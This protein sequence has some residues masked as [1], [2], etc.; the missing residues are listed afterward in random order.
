M[1]SRSHDVSRIISDYHSTIASLKTTDHDVPITKFPRL[2]TFNRVSAK[3]RAA[4][5]DDFECS[6]VMYSSALRDRV[7]GSFQAFTDIVSCLERYGRFI[8][9]FTGEEN[10]SFLCAINDA[11]LGSSPWSTI[12][13]AIWPSDKPRSA[14]LYPELRVSAGMVEG[15][16]YLTLSNKLEFAVVFR[17]GHLDTAYNSLESLGT[18]VRF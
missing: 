18:G 5:E 12:I 2:D 11:P 4:V 7:K 10:V 1:A 17:F 14:C 13:N 8:I 9:D 16:S 6:C 15:S 3:S